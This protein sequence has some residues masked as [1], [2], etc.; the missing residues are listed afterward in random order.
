[1]VDEY[2][3][4]ANKLCR[5]DGGVQ[6]WEAWESENIDAS[7]EVRLA[8]DLPKIHSAEVKIIH[9]QH[10]AE[11]LRTQNC[12]VADVR[13][14]DESRG[15]IF[16]GAYKDITFNTLRRRPA[17][18]QKRLAP[19]LEDSRQ[20]VAISNTGMRCAVYCT[21]LVDQ[22]GFDSNRICWLKGGLCE[23]DAWHKK[24]P[25][26]GEEIRRDYGLPKSRGRLYVVGAD[27]DGGAAARKHSVGLL[28]WNS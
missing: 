14:L 6:R 5:L 12:L 25:E 23:W 22:F 10:L 18:A 26:Q 4:R 16:P 19:L 3:F 2:E 7:N 15:K 9:A 13:E 27:T 24:N 8:Y 1:L 17:E 21:M 11:M 20:I 28:A